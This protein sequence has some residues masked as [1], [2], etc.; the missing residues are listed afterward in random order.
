MKE[1]STASSPH[2]KSA[3]STGRI[4]A[5]VLIAL[6]PALAVGIW[7]LGLRA[8]LIALISVAASLL[9]E[10]LFQ[11]VVHR[12]VTL[13]DGSAAVTGLLLAMT[14]PASVPCW[15][16]VLGAF[17]AIVVVKGLFGGL[18]QNVLNPAL[19]GRAFL[20][21]LFP[22]SVVRYPALGQKLRV[23]G[24]AVDAVST[25][26][27][28]HEMRIPALPD[29]SLWDM[30]LGRIPGSIG[31]ISALALLLGGAYLLA[32]RVISLRIPAAYLGT[33]ALLTLLFPKAQNA[34]VWMLY[35][36]LGGG[37]MLAAFFMATDYT[38]SPVTPWGQV[39]YGI[40]CGVITVLLRS[41]GLFPEGVTYAVLLMNGLVCLLD[42]VAAPRRFGGQKGG[43]A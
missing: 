43:G 12:P 28:L 42:R 25:A 5:D 19:A 20:L 15:V 2:I 9:F 39:L 10:G 26:T 3:V 31:E 41:F 8:L 13:T 38:T 4:M 23:F 36:L 40:G 29:A 32:R 21:L 14:L 1:L 30:F 22:A 37:L 33:V 11:L 7:V 16:A 27:P 18:G 24:S 17:F 6:L 34:A 35:H